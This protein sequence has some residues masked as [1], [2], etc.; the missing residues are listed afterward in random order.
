MFK[1]LRTKL[2]FGLAPLLAVTVGLGVWAI[3]MF[4]RLGG[5]HR[6]DPQ[7]E[8]PERAGR[9]GHE[10][11]TGADGLVAAVRDRRR[12]GAGRRTQFAEYRSMFERNLKIEQ[13]NVTLPGEQQMVDTLSAP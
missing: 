5:K 2:L 13:G 1:T 10:R 8:L 9:G 4:S 11:G 6:R 3:V 12:G 7:G